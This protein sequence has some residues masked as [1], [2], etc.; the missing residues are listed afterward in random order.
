MP[1]RNFPTS[2]NN[3]INFAVGKAD[4][5]GPFTIVTLLR[6]VELADNE[7]LLSRVAANGEGRSNWTY[8][9]LDRTKQGPSFEPGGSAGQR[10]A[11][12]H[13]ALLVMVRTATGKKNRYYIYDF[14][15][16]AWTAKEDAAISEI[17]HTG[18]PDHIA[19]ARAGV[20]AN[21][22][23]AVAACAIFDR[24]F[25]QAEAEQIK[26]LG[27]IRHWLSME[28]LSLWMFN[29]GVV[30]E[31]VTDQTGNGANQIART[32]TTV[33]LEEPPIPYTQGTTPPVSVMPPVVGG[34]AEVGEL[35]SATAGEWEG[36]PE[37]YAYEWQKADEEEGPWTKI[38]TFGGATL[39]VGNDLADKFIRCVVTAA[40]TYGSTTEPSAAVG[41][42]ETLTFAEVGEEQ[43]FPDWQPQLARPPAPLYD[44][45]GV[46]LTEETVLG[47]FY[48]GKG[49]AVNL[50]L[51]QT[52]GNKA[53]RVDA[54]WHVNPARTQPYAVR[55][56]YLHP[57]AG[58]L[59]L[60]L[61]AE[62]AHVSFV[63]VP[64]AAGGEATFRVLLQVA[65]GTVS[66]PRLGSSVL[67]DAVQVEVAKEASATQ[68]IAP[69]APGRVTLAVAASGEGA[70]R[71]LTL[72]QLNSKG[73]W[74]R[75][76]G[77]PLLA[78]SA[79]TQGLLTLPASPVRVTL[80]NTTAAAIKVDLAIGVS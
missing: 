10:L 12:G 58:E 38:A 53:F 41:P 56:F 70:G 76:L 18:T 8:A 3:W 40:N 60:Q 63:L 44:T 62:A 21:F 25:T 61:P 72:E 32:G 77:F 55:S 45:A 79:L 39:K 11:V 4:P 17:K 74:A 52:A 49:A 51:Q 50:L 68:L 1:I 78:A 30:T 69:T 71:T 75:Y 65:P 27:W 23:A 34:L 48:V 59:H 19:F 28:P 5:L 33:L 20:S 36:E 16:A 31:T 22:T 43:G 26:G 7:P 13:W 80:G 15:T 6:R 42:V 73:E 67:L 37:S 54:Y 47:P 24:A 66:E 9:E 29:Q 14:T 35:L 64:L 57:E 2:T 46:T